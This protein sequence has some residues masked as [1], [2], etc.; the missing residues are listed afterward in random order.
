M[1]SSGVTQ[2]VNRNNC[3]FNFYAKEK[4]FVKKMDY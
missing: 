3:I 2:D 1:P 4:F